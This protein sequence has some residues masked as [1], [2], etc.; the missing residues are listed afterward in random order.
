MSSTTIILV[1]T[2]AV[3]FFGLVFAAVNLAGTRL[4]GQQIQEDPDVRKSV[5]PELRDDD[6]PV[7]ADY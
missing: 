4:T 2:G 3:V 6:F 7:S 1:V 5:D